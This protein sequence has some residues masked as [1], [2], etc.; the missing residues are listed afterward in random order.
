MTS[1]RPSATARGLAYAAMRGQSA[2]LKRHPGIDRD[3]FGHQG[4]H[5][6]LQKHR[7]P[8]RILLAHR[9]DTGNEECGAGNGD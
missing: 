9:A 3:H 8:R 5:R 1:I 4:R 6:A 7:T 2:A